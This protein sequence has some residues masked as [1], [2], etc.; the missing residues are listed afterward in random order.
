MQHELLGAQERNPMISGVVINEYDPIS[1]PRHG[2]I[3]HRP[4]EI[5]VNEL[6]WLSGASD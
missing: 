1:L 2:L 3:A 4:V 5:R 6:E